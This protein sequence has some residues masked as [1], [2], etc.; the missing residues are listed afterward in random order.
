MR[1]NRL[2]LLG[3]ALLVVAGLSQ[4]KDGVK[5]EGPKWFLAPPQGEGIYGVGMEHGT[6]PAAASRGADSLACREVSKILAT[7][8]AG[9]ARNARETGNLEGFEDPALASVDALGAVDQDLVPCRVEKRDSRKDG[10]GTFR[11]YSLVFVARVQAVTAAK[12]MQARR[13]EKGVDNAHD[14]LDNAVRTT[15]PTGGQ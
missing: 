7:K 3:A 10:D 9:W 13:L 5:V 14:E 8:V 6:D 1:S 11:A 2:L 15:G 4:A 12:A